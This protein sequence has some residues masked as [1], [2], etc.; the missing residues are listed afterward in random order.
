MHDIGG[1]SPVTTSLNL[2]TNDLLADDSDILSRLSLMDYGSAEALAGPF[3]GLSL[4]PYVAFL[5]FLNCKENKT[6]KGVTVGFVALLLFVFLTIPAAIAAKVWYG[7]SLADCDWLHASAESLLTGTNL[8]TVVAFRQA[9]AATP[10]LPHDDDLI[11]DNESR[12][13]PSS[14]TNYAPMTWLMAIWTAAAGVTAVIPAAF[15]D[16]SVHDLYLGGFLDLP[17]SLSNLLEGRSQP[18]NA[19]SVGCWI[20]HISSLVEFLAIMDY[21][22]LWSEST[23]NTKWKGLVWGLLPLHSSG[24]TACTYH[25]FYNQLPVLVPLQALLTCL[26]NTTAAFAAWRIAKSNGWE[27]TLRFTMK[28]EDEEPLPATP[29]IEAPSSETVAFVSRITPMLEGVAA[30]GSLYTF[31]L[32]LF[33]GCAFASYAIKYGETWLPVPF[34]PDLV[35]AVSFIGIASTLN[36]I[37]W[38]RRSQDSSFDGWL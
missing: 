37:K 33:L 1:I 18:I 20:I 19:L 35:A 26:G 17:V 5:Y 31:L 27:P 22:W 38:Q 3:F 8:V 34:E 32:K 25:F 30:F 24:L 13:L 23:R 2:L 11:E 4:F 6:P 29:R 14:M 21:C 12:Q 15:A 16:M 9:L 7:V 28:E 36:A 10:L